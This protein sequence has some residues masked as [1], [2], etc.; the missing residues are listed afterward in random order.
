MVYL[1]ILLIM[2]DNLLTISLLFLMSGIGQGS[3]YVLV[4]KLVSYKAEKQRS[5]RPF[6]YFQSIT[7][8]GRFMGT[9][10]F[11][12]TT[13]ISLNLGILSLTFYDLFSL[14]HFLIIIGIILKINNVDG[15]S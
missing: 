7:S 13:T 3:I 9:F 10:L 2:S 15:I 14:I 1:W 11:G 6:S 5:A 4:M 8:T 12:F